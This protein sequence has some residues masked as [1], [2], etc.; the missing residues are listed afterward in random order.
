MFNLVKGTHDVILDEA[1][2]YTYIE[3]IL[4][5]T[6]QLFNYKEFRTPIIENNEL[7]TRSVGDSSDIVR[8]EMYTFEDKGGRLITLRP[9]ITAGLVRSMVNAKLF[10][11]QDFP[12]K[13]YYTGPCFRYER[14]Q[15]GRYRQFNQFGVECIG[16]TDPHRDSEVISMG[17]DSLIMLGF[18]SITLKINSLGDNETRENYK[19]A[20][21][22]YFGAH[23]QDMCEDCKQRYELNVLRILD[24]KTPN[25]QEIVKKAPRISDYLSP[26]AR[27]SFETIKKDL[28]LL[29]IPYEVDD[30]LVRGLDYYTGVVFEFQY[31]S[32]KGKDYGAIAGGGHY[33]KLVSEIGGPDVEGCGYA[34]GI[35]RLAS[36]MTDDD[37]FEDLTSNLDIYIMPLGNLAVE[38]SLQIANFLRVSG[39]TCEICLEN[40]GMSQM[41]KKAE[42][43]NALYAIIIGEN[44]LTNKEFVIKNLISQEQIKVK[45]DDLLDKLDELFNF[46]G[47]K[48][49]ECCEGD[50]DCDS[51]CDC[52]CSCE[53]K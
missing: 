43:R 18:K 15:Q 42:R 38:A 20:L 47:K 49:F 44:E 11:N 31:I 26:A 14:P 3:N 46:E 16:I 33:G 28:D 48:K 5:N 10:A 29:G 40:K 22:E 25:D 24:C 35:E 34:M 7:F 2:K 21:R 52:E 36:V 32:S 9:E 12:L 41:F 17:Y 23:I 51:D 4:Q 13:A 50:C 53:C 8:K 6:A 19:N 45:A 37:L 1:Q 39:Y 27:E 30:S